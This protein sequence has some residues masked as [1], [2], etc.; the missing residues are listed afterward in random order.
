MQR[1]DMKNHEY[2]IAAVAWQESL[3]QAYRSLHV[4]VQSIL[5]ALGV[6]LFVVPLTDSPKLTLSAILIAVLLLMLFFLHAKSSRKFAGVVLAR[7]EDINWWHARLMQCEQNMPSQSRYFTS[8]KI[9][10]QKQRG[11]NGNLLE[12]KYLSDAPNSQLTD[13]DCRSLIGTGLGH[14]RMVIDQQL[15]QWI[16]V[17]WFF[18][19]LA[20]AGV[21]IVK[22]F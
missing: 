8:F 15:F 17:I 19:L 9:H 12:Q 14:T 6:G 22:L 4:T 20:T 11:E 18:I 1:E 2:I 3:L 16:E 7:G 5:L 10:Q 13:E 21:L